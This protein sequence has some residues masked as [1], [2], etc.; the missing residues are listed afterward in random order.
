MRWQEH[1]PVLTPETQERIAPIAPRRPGPGRKP[2]GR[3]LWKVS[4]WVSP[5]DR[6]RIQDGLA[7]K[8]KRA[9]DVARRALYTEAGV[10]PQVED[11]G[12]E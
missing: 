8:G 3:K 5:E 7:S 9:G 10:D 2:S 4:I 6:Q 12:E 11:D 1:V